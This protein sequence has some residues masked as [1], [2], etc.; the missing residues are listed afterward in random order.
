MEKV[1]LD[2]VA[3][4]LDTLSFF[5][6]T[7]DLYGEKRLRELGELLANPSWKESRVFAV[8]WGALT[9]VFYW[10]MFRNYEAHITWYKQHFNLVEALVHDFTALVFIVL[11]IVSFLFMFPVMKFL[12]QFSRLA[13][14]FIDKWK[15]KGTFLTIGAIFFV[16][17]RLIAVLELVESK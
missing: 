17:A 12:S 14:F 7:T 10:F 15:M 8:I 9:I 16:A 11:G 6:V 3:T 2:L 13:A 4:C 5:L 1:H